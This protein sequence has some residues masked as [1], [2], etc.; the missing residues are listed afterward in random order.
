MVSLE[1]G[2][3][4]ESHVVWQFP[5]SACVHVTHGTWNMDHR[6][7]RGS[8]L[9]L[10]SDLGKTI[11]WRKGKERERKEKKRKGGKQKEKKICTWEK[12]GKER[13]ERGEPV[14]HS[15]IFGVSMVGSR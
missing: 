15:L 3:W 14:V 12:K 7:V 11:R 1:E 6:K 5:P 8:F 10:G 9:S 2:I 13:R 4:H